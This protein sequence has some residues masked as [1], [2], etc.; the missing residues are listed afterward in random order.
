MINKK[1]L[2]SVMS[3]VTSLAMV[4]GATFAF[5]TDTA[6]STANTF[7]SGTL[8]LLVDDANEPTP[9]PSVT[10][11]LTISDFAPGQST[12]GFIS[13]HNPG[14][15]AIAE[16]E[17]TADTTPTDG[18]TDGS[19]IRNVLQLAVVLDDTVTPDPACADGVNLTST[20]EPLVGNGDGTLTLAEF[21]NGTDEYDAL[22]GLVSGATRNVCFTVTFDPDA[23]D[24]YQ[25][26][27]AST[28]FSFKAN[29][30]ASQ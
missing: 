22:P 24:I 28:T 1:I 18:G 15:L 13:L 12:T 23:T 9:A 11:S 26:D 16:V 2:I 7:S 30:N 29:Q 5:F 20:I 14:T 10:G 27:S 4:G 17:L 8:N 19:D 21:D 3:I 6:T 25:G